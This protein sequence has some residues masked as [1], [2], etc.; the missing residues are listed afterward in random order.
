MLIS[1]GNTTLRIRNALLRRVCHR[2]R[3]VSCGCSLRVWW[4]F[5]H[6]GDTVVDRLTEPQMLQVHFERSNM[7]QSGQGSECVC[8]QFA[9]VTLVKY[10]STFVLWW[11]ATIWGDAQ[12]VAV[13]LN[14]ILAEPIP[15]GRP[16][17]LAFVNYGD[18]HCNL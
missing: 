6:R 15:R 12:V 4:V 17:G 11:Q 1:Y 7:D 5:H 10:L 13:M 14:F 8:N 9:V 18:S 16:Q 3:G 2:S